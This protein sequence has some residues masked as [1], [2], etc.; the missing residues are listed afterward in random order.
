VKFAEIV[1]RLTGLSTPILV[2]PWLL[3]VGL[4]TALAAVILVLP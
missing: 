4:I 3:G 1:A 2:R